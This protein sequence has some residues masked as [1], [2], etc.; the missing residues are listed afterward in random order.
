MTNSPSPQS[1]PRLEVYSDRSVLVDE[2]G[3]QSEF[4]EGT[5]TDAAK[6]RLRTLKESLG[7]G[8]LANIIQNLKTA[9]P[10]ID[11]IDLTHLGILEDLVQS[12]TSEVGRAIVGLTI[13]QL[14]VKA[15][16]PAQSIR[17]HKGGGTR[18]G[19]FSW[20]E[21]ISMR[22]LDKHFITPVLR[23]YNLL[24][25]NADGFM[26]TRSLAENYPYSLLYKAA[27]RGGKSQWLTVTELVESGQLDSL[28]ALRHLL[29]LLINR[30]EI[31]QKSADQALSSVTSVVPSITTLQDAVDFIKDYV[32]ASPYSARVFEIALHSLFQALED[33]RVFEGA[34]KP[35]CQMRSANKKHGNIGDIEV[36]ETSTSLEILEAWDAKYGKPYLRDELE[37]LNEKL[38][39]HSETKTAGFVVD[40]PPNLKEEIR[41]RLEEI[42]DLHDL[43]ILV[44][45][46]EDWVA[47]MAKRTELDPERLGQMW[48]IAFAE[49]LCQ[50][51]RER[52]PID[53]PSDAWVVFLRDHADQWK[54]Q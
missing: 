46:F 54:K 31:F 35:L 41:T 20:R 34:L 7:Q 24:R 21:G 8:F 15:I 47:E 42:S 13:L 11:P 32:D 19:G 25:L 51:R 12:M 5:P 26:M 17:L 1:E 39:D 28:K 30:S 22:V 9:S 43:Q 6:Q 18:G 27:I 40:G 49:S 16:V 52:A 37:E 3:A 45:S 38:C 2:T 14:S 53:E 10:D 23:Q 36:A 29:S 4:K 48:I 50:R 33:Q 44:L